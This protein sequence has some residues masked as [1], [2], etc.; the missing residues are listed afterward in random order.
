[1][2]AMTVYK[3][4]RDRVNG[5]LRDIQTEDSTH[6][7]A[8]Y[9]ASKTV[10]HSYCERVWKDLWVLEVPRYVAL[11]QLFEASR[12]PESA[13]NDLIMWQLDGSELRTITLRYE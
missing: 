5:T 3:S 4:T 9:D 7:R 1:M 12:F 13:R 8:K 11:L 6:Y 10:R 2:I